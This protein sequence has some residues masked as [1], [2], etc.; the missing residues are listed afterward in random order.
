[1]EQ[2]GLITARVEY[3]LLIAHP[4]MARDTF[5]PMA[6]VDTSLLEAHNFI[7]PNRPE[8]YFGMLTTCP[9]WVKHGP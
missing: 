7:G 6:R 4:I 3:G 1:M 9:I 8:I 2:L 5:Q